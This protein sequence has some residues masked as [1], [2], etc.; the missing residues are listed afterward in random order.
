MLDQNQKEKIGHFGE[1]NKFFANELNVSERT[2]SKVFKKLID[3]RHITVKQ[4]YN[5]SRRM[6]Y[7]IF[8]KSTTSLLIIQIKRKSALQRNAGQFS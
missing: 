2:I 1:T 8:V 3:G 4:V 5:R 6:N 7:K